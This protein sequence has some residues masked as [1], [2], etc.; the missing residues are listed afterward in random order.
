MTYEEAATE[1]SE[2][3]EVQ[4]DDLLFWTQFLHERDPNSWV[5][6]VNNGLDF[7]TFEEAYRYYYGEEKA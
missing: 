6:T 2:S 1:F 3:G 5:V 4:I 7:D